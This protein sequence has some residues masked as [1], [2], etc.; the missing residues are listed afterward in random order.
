MIPTTPKVS[1][2]DRPTL[3]RSGFQ[4]S[5]LPR[6]QSVRVFVVSRDP[7]YTAVLIVRQHVESSRTIV[8]ITV[9]G[10][11][12]L[13]KRKIPGLGMTA[14]SLEGYAGRKFSQCYL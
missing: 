5:S 7:Y 10:E 2:A 4:L 14:S 1:A 9:G 12:I 8:R 6:A 3:R 13:D 11:V